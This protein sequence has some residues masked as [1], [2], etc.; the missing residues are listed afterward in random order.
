MLLLSSYVD[1]TR[2]ELFLYLFENLA[3]AC[4]RVVLLHLELTLDL[5][6][7]LTRK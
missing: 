4:D 2:L 5:L 7:V 6:F 3:F 1:K